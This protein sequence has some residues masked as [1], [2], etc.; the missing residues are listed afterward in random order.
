MKT[1]Q[2]TM[3]LSRNYG[4]QFR[5]SVTHLEQEPKEMSLTTICRCTDIEAWLRWGEQN[6]RK[7]VEILNTA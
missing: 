5:H 1:S 6:Q 7:E 2:N 3:S 4:N